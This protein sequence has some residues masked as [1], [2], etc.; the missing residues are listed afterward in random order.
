MTE[1]TA[2]PFTGWPSDATAFLAELA[3][4]NTRAFWTANVDRYRTA[5]L[6]PTR[7]LVAALGAEFGPGR[8]FR[9]YVDRRFRPNADPYRTDTGA[10]VTGPGGTPYVVVLAAGGLSVQ[11]GYQAFDASQLRRY[12]AAADGA[13]GEEL[14]GVLA[15]LHVEGLVPADVPVLAG[16]PRGCPPDHPRL[17]FMRL[18]GLHV[19]RTW[20][21]GPWL[22][23]PD[24]LVRVR[25]AWQATRPLA[26]WLD[27]HVG[28]RDA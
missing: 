15:A 12:R 17:E 3:D 11:V 4:A 9:P 24:A 19:D 14:E 28:P 2:A 1:T 16:R 21:A 13:A 8:V 5:V 23:T 22:Q 7:A 27:A 18:R 6:A 25:A 10:L 26:D 20:P